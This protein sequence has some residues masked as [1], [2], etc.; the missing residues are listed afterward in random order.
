MHKRKERRELKYAF[1]SF[2]ILPHII[3]VYSSDKSFAN[4]LEWA[5]EKGTGWSPSYTVQT[6][7][8]NLVSFLNEMASQSSYYANQMKDNIAV[9]RS[10]NCT[11]CGHT[12]SKPF[13]ELPKVASESKKEETSA[14]KVPELLTCYVSKVRFDDNVTNTSPIFGY[15]IARSGSSYNPSLTSPCEIMTHEAFTELSKSGKIESVMREELHYWLPLF[16]TPAHGALIKKYFEASIV[17]ITEAKSFDPKLV[18]QVLPKLL[19]STVVTF[20]NGTTHTSERA[21]HGYFA[22]HRLF[23]WAVTEYPALSVAIEK[24]IKDFVASP[25]ARTKKNT[26]NVGEWL[27]LLLVSKETSW[28]TAAQAYLT[29]NFERNVMWYL[30]EKKE[31]GNA[32]GVDEE[33]RL[34]ETFRLTKVSRDLLAFQVLFLDI[35][36]P[37]EMDF[38]QISARYDANYGLPTEQM[39][40]EMKD[41]VKK[42]KEIKSYPEW[43]AIIKVP[44]PGKSQLAGILVKSVQSAATKDGYFDK[45]GGNRGGGGG[46]RGGGRGGRGR[47]Y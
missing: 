40:K 25:D 16:I 47:G 26:P 28:Q 31:L 19:N 13:P 22:F 14:S 21:L 18:M 37:K 46:G 35:A 5:N 23:L 42:I 36:K 32:T 12:H 17:K 34:S 43:F 7:L 39:E 9:S 11:D 8:V 20:M 10:L 1:P 44:L 3:L 6:V 29:E 4:L 41:A 24:K 30:R 27:A 38:A 33:V 45:P 2:P 15:G